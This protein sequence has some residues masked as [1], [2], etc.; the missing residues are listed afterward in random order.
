M[1]LIGDAQSKHGD[2][3]GDGHGH[4]REH[5]RARHGS[6]CGHGYGYGHEARHGHGDGDGDGY[7]AADGHLMESERQKRRR[8]SQVRQELEDDHELDRNLKSR[9][10]VRAPL[11]LLVI[12]YCTLNKLFLVSKVLHF[13]IPVHIWAQSQ[14]LGDSAT[15]L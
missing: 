6:R 12:N 3:H 1:A 5:G 15:D 8:E 10:Y 2:G 4:G 13:C 11:E 7:P 9:T 14:R